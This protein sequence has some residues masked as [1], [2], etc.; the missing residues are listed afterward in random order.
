[1]AELKA[2][3][4]ES[5]NASFGREAFQHIAIEAIARTCESI[6]E[7]HETEEMIFAQASSS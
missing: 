7:H 5:G 3:R 1:M 2:S 4:T 6:L